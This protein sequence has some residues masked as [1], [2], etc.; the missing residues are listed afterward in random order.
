M[1]KDDDRLGIYIDFDEGV[2]RY[3]INDKDQGVALKAD[4]IAEGEFCVAISYYTNN[5]HAT[6]VP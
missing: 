2:V 6:F 1:L 5:P 4:R 3:L